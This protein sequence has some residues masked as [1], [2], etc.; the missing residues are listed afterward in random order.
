MSIYTNLRDAG[1]PIDSYESDLYCKFTK[2]S[3]EIV[4]DSGLKVHTFMNELDHT[5]WYD[6]PFMYDPWWENRL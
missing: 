4:K 1:I 3:A 6:I 5:L 2:E